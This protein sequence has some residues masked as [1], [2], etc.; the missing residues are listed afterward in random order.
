MA[1]VAY[2]FSTLPTLSETLAIS[3]VRATRSLGLDCLWLANRRPRPGEFHPDD[4]DLA[5]TTFYL[6]PVKPLLYARALGW[7][8]RRFPRGFRQAWRLAFTLREE[9]EAQILRHLA[10]LAGAAVLARYCQQQQ[11]AH[12]HVHY[13]FGAAEVALFLHA[14]TGIPYSLSIHGSDVLLANPFLE[15]KLAGARFVISNCHYHLQHLLRR[16]PSLAN[17]RFFV[18]PGG[19]DLQRGLWASSTPPAPAG[20]LRLLLVGRLT[21][22][23]A[24]DLLLEACARLHNLQ[25]PFLCR[26]VGEGPEKHRLQQLIQ[27][28]GLGERVQ[29]LGALFQDEVARLYDWSQVLVLSSRS[30]GTPMTIIE[31][32]AKARPVVAPRFTAIPEMVEDGQTGLLFEPGSVTD[33]AAKLARLA[34]DPELRVKLGT[35]ARQQAAAKFDLWANARA[36]LTILAREVPALS[37][38]QC[39]EEP[40]ACGHK[41]SPFSHYA[42][43]R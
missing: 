9:A 30:E 12:I 13:A 15:A 23:K 11:V 7:A 28:L 34:S 26:I 16:F 29:L 27:R 3:Q 31:A 4:Q 42:L 35:A 1:R 36:F 40:H 19:V 21:P 22:V 24:I 8:S 33:L 39:S 43:S 25:L 10:H 5:E 17:Q 20:P 18:V 2:F 37:R 14:L 38:L 6:T 41:V 32:M